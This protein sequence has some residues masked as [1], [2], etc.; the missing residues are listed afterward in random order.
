MIILEVP[1]VELVSDPDLTNS[2]PNPNPIRELALGLLI[3]CEGANHS[4][5][6][7]TIDQRTPNLFEEGR[8]E[9]ILGLR[10]SILY[11]VANSSSNPTWCAFY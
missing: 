2:D 10:K 11:E 9:L 7:R 6:K 5:K 8:G 3:F 4:S 1:E